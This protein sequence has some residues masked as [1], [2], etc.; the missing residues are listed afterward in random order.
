MGIVESLDNA[1]SEL[2][3][4]KVRINEAITKANH[5]LSKNPIPIKLQEK[6]CY[7]VEENFLIT[8][9]KRDGSVQ[10]SSPDIDFVSDYIIDKF[11]IKTIFGLK[12]ESIYVYEN[13][14]WSLTGKGL[15]KSEIERV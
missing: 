2:R 1:A 11:D 13:G 4:N 10:S 5:E 12:E 8:K 9:Y 15:I 3:K 7:D 6:P 14:V